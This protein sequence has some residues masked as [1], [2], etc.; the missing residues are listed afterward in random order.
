MAEIASFRQFALDVGGDLLRCGLRCK[1]LDYMSL[2]VDQ[3]FGEVPLDGIAEDSALFVLEK[4][5]EWVGVGAVAWS[6]MPT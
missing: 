1:A 5:V 3:E 4:L 2:L 6:L